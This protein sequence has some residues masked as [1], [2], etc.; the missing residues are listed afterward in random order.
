MAVLIALTTPAGALAQEAH[1]P[2]PQQPPDPPSQ[3]GKIHRLSEVQVTAEAYQDEPASPK[4]TAPLLNTPQTITV[5][6]QQVI[7]DQNLLGLTQIL[8]TLPGITFGAGEAAGGFGDNI[9]IDGFTANN[10]I[11]VDGMRDS[12]QYSRT[13]AFDL[14]SVE[15]VSGA[16]SAIGGV[17][18]V[19]GAINLVTKIAT[20]GAYNLETLGIG[21]D[22]YE[23]FTADI[24]QQLDSDTAVR[25][26][27]MAHENDVPGRDAE[28][29]K[30]WGVAPSVTFG[31]GTPTRVTLSYSHQHDDNVPQYGV[32][33]F[34]GHILPGAS[35]H[36]YYGFSN[37]DT[38]KIDTD[39]AQAAV[40]HDFSPHLSARNQTRYENVSQ[41]SIVDPPAGTYCLADDSSPINK[42]AGIGTY[43]SCPS[44]V[45]VGDYRRSTGNVPGH[46]R[47]ATN[48]M[49]ANET[50]VT[51]NFSTGFVR[52]DLVTGASFSHETFRLTD[53]SVQRSADGTYYHNPP[54]PIADPDTTYTGPVNFIISN[55]AGYTQSRL[56]DEAVY[57][58]D[59]MKFTD[60]WLFNF[61]VRYESVDGSFQDTTASLTST[62]LFNGVVYNPSR[63]SD[64]TLFSYRAG[65][66]FKPVA[67]GTIYFAYGN[68]KTPSMSSVDGS[69]TA[70]T[71]SVAPETAGTFELGTKWELLQGRLLLSGSLFRDDRSNYL[72]ADPDDPNNPAGLS[73]VNGSS[74]VEGITVGAAGEITDR[75]AIFANYT[76]LESKVLRSVSDYQE[77]Q[78]L[79]YTRGE[80]HS[81]R[82]PGVEDVR[83][84]G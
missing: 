78:G 32:P 56:D 8:N 30:R 70:A 7:E 81:V 49:I 37:L 2:Q 79:D 60:Q 73:Q 14:E 31:L 1:L 54:T 11:F 61:G 45:P 74:R 18:G 72:V 59:T 34:N 76:V 23:R 20:A 67:N 3:A 53:G 55:Q 41:L 25:L 26:N 68:S 27:L 47:D 40:D 63:S 36:A 42:G 69:C 21:T 51:W 82:P 38:Q 10:N 77:A 12:A 83:V 58:F 22:N 64:N 48:Q 4:Y 28:N 50:D 35:W 57:A 52:H 44:A 46:L 66:M 75:W 24:N 15:L 43:G 16:D 19:G 17:G 71:C 6:P 39:F 84:G 80:C 5:V 33:T 29:F 9:N 13:D 62:G 65:L